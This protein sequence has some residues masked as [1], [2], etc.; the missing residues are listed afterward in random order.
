MS[1]ELLVAVSLIQRH[2]RV[3][4]G[5]L[6]PGDRLKEDRTAVSRIE[7]NFPKLLY[8]DHGKKVVTEMV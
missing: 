3:N 6:P 5:K 1:E 8:L 4:I 2:E 7:L